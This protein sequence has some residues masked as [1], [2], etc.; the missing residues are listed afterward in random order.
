MGRKAGRDNDSMESQTP[1]TAPSTPPDTE[2]EELPATSK[3]LGDEEIKRMEQEERKAHLQ[4]KRAQLAK[5]KRLAAKDRV[6]DKETSEAKARE[7]DELL[8]KSAAFS[9]ILTKK[10]QVL[11]RVGSGFDGKALGEH[12]L[13]MAEQQK[14]GTT[15]DTDLPFSAADMCSVLGITGPSSD[16]P[17]PLKFLQLG[18]AAP[19]PV[20]LPLPTSD[21]AVAAAATDRHPREPCH[22]R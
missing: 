10:T 5:Q 1:T 18:P 19:F 15:S 4:N 13:Q 6:L 12:D 9:N 7:L 3:I 8:A 17:Q 20:S 11:G 22:A 2:A 16:N 21:P 14:T